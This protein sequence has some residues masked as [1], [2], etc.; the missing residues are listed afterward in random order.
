[1][2][3]FDGFVVRYSKEGTLLWARHGGADANDSFLGV[4]VG[5]DDNSIA[6]GSTTPK[7][8][9]NRCKLQDAFIEKFTAD[10]Q[11]RWSKRPQKIDFASSVAVT[12][13]G[14]VYVG[15]QS[16][17][18]LDKPGIS[19]V[20]SQNFVKRTDGLRAHGAL[21]EIPDSVFTRLDCKRRAIVEPSM[22]VFDKPLESQCFLL[23]E[24][25]VRF[26]IVVALSWLEERHQC[27]RA[28]S[29]PFF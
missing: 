26:G 2:G 7:A 22:K 11:K 20:S 14:E 3:G 18:D 8:A 10:G 24:Q 16:L 1:L 4:A 13:Q 9:E 23:P 25:S 28:K 15:G 29:G 27:Q 5:A 21:S 6:V 12:S 19:G 17:G